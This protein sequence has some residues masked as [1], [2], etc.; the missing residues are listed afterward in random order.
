MRLKRTLLAIALIA[1]IA[2]PAFTQCNWPTT[3][4]NDGTYVAPGVLLSG[5]VS[6]A[7]CSGTGPGVPGNMENAMSWDP[8]TLTLGGQ[9]KVWG[10]AIDATGAVETARSIDGSGNGWI[11]YTTNYN[12]GQFWL[13]GS[14]PWGG[15]ATNFTGYLTYY[16][17]S[18]RVSYIGGQM[19]GATSN[20]FF[21]GTFNDCPNCKIEYTIANAMFVW[22]TGMPGMPANYPPFICGASSGE[23]FDACCII[24][25]IFC[26]PIGTETSTW[27][28]IKSIYR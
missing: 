8:T 16:N 5:R 20:V 11:D 17:V 1:F 18:T 15:G 24:A 14:G 26:T 27:G 21:T 25:K 28:A 13:S 6:E 3:K 2:S 22:R 19:V 9:W 4:P 10:M 23:Y 7:W 12:G